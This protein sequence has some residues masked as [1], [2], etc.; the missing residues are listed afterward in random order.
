[1][2]KRAA[3]VQKKK[4]AL[5]RQKTAVQSKALIAAM[6][7]EKKNFDTSISV[8]TAAD[9]VFRPLNFVT[10]GAANSERIGNQIRVANLNLR[11]NLTYQP[12]AGENIKT[13]RIVVIQD[14]AV[15]GVLPVFTDVLTVAG[16]TSF[17]NPNQL[18]RF[19]IIHDQ[20]YEMTPPGNGQNG[21]AAS[22]AQKF[23]T[24][25]KTNMNL[26]ILFNDTVVG[27]A[28]T[29]INLKTTGLFFGVIGVG[30]GFAV[31]GTARIKYFD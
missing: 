7:P 9:D 4:P 2:V 20:N 1:M 26:P 30:Q 8:F 17:R 29:I 24:I 12:G 11:L 19:E 14:N 6:K 16:T 25:S 28:P 27:V 5:K 18:P 21:T 22:D 31:S 10:L 3:T 13:I 23:I 15:N